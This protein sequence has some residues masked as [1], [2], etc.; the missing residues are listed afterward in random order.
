MKNAFYTTI[1]I[2][3]FIF[4]CHLPAWGMLGEGQ[5]VL[6]RWICVKTKNCVQQIP[7]NPYVAMCVF[8]MSAIY[9][10]ICDIYIC[11]VYMSA[12]YI[13]ICDIYICMVYMSAIYISR[14]IYMPYI[15]AIEIPSSYPFTSKCNCLI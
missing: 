2:R 10:C 9:I 8:Y 12:I 5:L 4:I 7:T 3:D 11:K 6:K 13:C 14:H 15:Y 1:S